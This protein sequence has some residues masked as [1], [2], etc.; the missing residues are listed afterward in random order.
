MTDHPTTKQTSPGAPRTA[1]FSLGAWV[2]ANA[3]GLGA[4]F[5]SFA[6]VG[7]V[8]EAMGADH[9]SL[10]RN[11]PAVLAMAAGGVVFAILRR[12]ALGAQHAGSRRQLLII[13]LSVPAGLFLG[14]GTP[15]FDW[16]GATLVGG[17][18]G[19]ALQLRALRPAGLRRVLASAGS[20]LAAG[21]ILTATA[22]V[23][24]DVL[25]VGAL[26]L[27]GDSVVSFVVI[28]TV[29]GLVA[30]ATGGAIEGVAL[31]RSIG[32]AD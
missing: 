1:A 29:L 30:G 23:L 24:I 26:G 8:L 2:R 22:I 14:L 17:T 10:L 3:V 28:L 11:V 13:G 27:D 19:G 4:S 6:L 7:G 25:L 12:G 31:R 21:L 18:V 15:P 9:N 32:R 16:I 20:W 5:G